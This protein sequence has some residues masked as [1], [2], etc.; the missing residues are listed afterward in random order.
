MG[1][2]LFS[3]GSAQLSYASIDYLAYWETA[4]KGDGSSSND[5]SMDD[6][7]DIKNNGEDMIVMMMV[8]VII[9]LTEALMR[10]QPYSTAVQ[11]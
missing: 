11:G 5:N 2:A 7:G 8:I 9:I 6:E 4:T 10:I 1:C 3:Y